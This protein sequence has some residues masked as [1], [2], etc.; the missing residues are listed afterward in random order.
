MIR[1]QQCSVQT[2]RNERGL[3]LAGIEDVAVGAVGL[4][5]EGAAG[6][7]SRPQVPM[8]TDP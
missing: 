2:V 7:T 1:R 8:R 4:V 6:P 3:L 5:G